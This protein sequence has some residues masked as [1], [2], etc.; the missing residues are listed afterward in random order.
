MSH[1]EHRQHAV[2]IGGSIGG[3]T[4]AKALAPHFAKVTL[5]ERDVL[6]D[7]AEPRR[8][9]PQGNQPHGILQRGRKE[10]DALFP[11][12]MDALKA[13][14]AFEFDGSAQMARFTPYGWAPRYDD[15]GASAFAC[16][17]PL[18][19]KTIRA[20]LKAQCPN[21]SFLD[22]T[23]VSELIYQKRGDEVWVTGVRTDHD[24]PMRREL[25]ADVVVD[26][27]GRGTKT[28]KWMQEVGL[29]LPKEVR[30]DSKC[31]YATRHY[32]APAE[33]QG[34]WWKA[35]LIDSAPPEH[36]R[37]VSILSVEKGRWIVTAIGV[38]G[39]YAPTDE[40]G[41]LAFIES[42]RSPLA[43]EVLRRA[44]PL[45]DVVQNRTTVNIWRHMHA[46]TGKLSGLLLMGDCVCGFNPSYGQ[47]MTASALAAQSLAERL[48]KHGGP[49]DYRFMKKHYASQARWIEEGWAYS[50]TLDLR[51]PQTQ[52]EKPPLYGL[53]RYC[54]S[55][56]EQVAI[57]DRVMM[58]KIIPLLDFGANRYSILTPSFIARLW[59]GLLRR[60][61]SRP[62]LPGPRDM[63]V[64]ARDHQAPL[65]SARAPAE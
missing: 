7:D 46:Y 37:A 54:T 62:E 3:M 42:A 1:P 33:A 57:H 4:A 64:F 6:V 10:L 20:L 61:V 5:I 63:D 2:I 38:N 19:E 14:G 40:A 11:G 55:L 16:T 17:R 9:V 31:N 43:A 29:P 49:L 45:T 8:G 32:R 25:G 44:E 12:L 39:D 26:A 35:L 52:G 59:I 18:L 30:V 56:L 22:G 41:W 65:L 27:T 47:G 53:M 50:T 21:V 60:L 34:W 24:D 13:Q 23:R 58:R 28:Y 51:W 15:I 48:R 36:T